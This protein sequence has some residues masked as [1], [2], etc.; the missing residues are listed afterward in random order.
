MA[1]LQL[2]VGLSTAEFQRNLDAK[3]LVKLLMKIKI[4]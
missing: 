3:E 2:S 1:N 4:W